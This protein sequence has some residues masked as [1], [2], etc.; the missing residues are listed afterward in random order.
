MGT[1]STSNSHSHFYAAWTSRHESS[2]TRALSSPRHANGTF[3]LR[4]GGA[5]VTKIG[6]RDLEHLLVGDYV[7]NGVVDCVVVD[8]V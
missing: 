2:M 7:P 8:V 4:E 3:T 6:V 5:G 1:H